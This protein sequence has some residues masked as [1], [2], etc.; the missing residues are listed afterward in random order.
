MLG[1]G[2]A[3]RQQRGVAKE[4]NTEASL[5]LVRST[6]SIVEDLERGDHDHSHD[7][8]DERG[9]EQVEQRLR[10]DWQKRRVGTINDR[11][12]VRRYACFGADFF[13]ALQQTVIQ[14]SVRRD[15]ALQDI[16]PDTKLLLGERRAL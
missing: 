16:V 13:V 3:L 2:F 1:R 4:G 15:F 6:N 5:N 11:N 7:Q 9:Q 12:I 14:L 10:R 8:T